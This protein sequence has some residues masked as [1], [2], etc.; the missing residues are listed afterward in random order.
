MKPLPISAFIIAH[1]EAHNLPR[2]LK[3]IEGW[4]SEIIVVIND[5]TDNTEEIAK[6]FGAKVF[7]QEWLGHREQKKVAFSKT[8][9]KWAFLIDSD[10]EVSPELKGS[11]IQFVTK[12]DPQYNG[13]Y[14]PR[15]VLFIDKWIRHG[16]WYPDY[17]TRLFRKEHGK[18]VG[19]SVHDKV[20]VSGKIKKLKGELRH[21]SFPSFN[22]EME[23]MLR[24]SDVFVKEQQS[25]GVRW[26][27]LRPLLRGFWRF[28]R[29]YFIRLGFLDGF[30]GFYIGCTQAFSTF[31]KHSRLYEVRKKNPDTQ[32]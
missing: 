28:F 4:V 24:Y 16:D 9:Q 17:S 26:S 7:E 2:L 8:T 12:D 11:I 5:C 15:C 29:H 25:K 3:S 10:E 14:F 20:E 31:Y 19:S 32:S 22:A 13:A 30:P 18:I 27:S 6:S 23:K 1:N 21:Y